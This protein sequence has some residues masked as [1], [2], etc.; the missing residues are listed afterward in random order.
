VDW[1]GRLPSNG[2]DLK[3]L[4]SEPCTTSTRPLTV[5]ALLNLGVIES[6]A[7]GVLSAT[8]ALRLFFHADNCL[9]V[10]NHLRDKLAN[11]IMSHGTQLPDLFTILP[12][13]EAHREFHRELAT[14]R[15]L[16]LKLLDDKRLVA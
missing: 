14:M 4:L 13:D 2:I 7:N 3:D 1:G 12:A 6:L 9:F 8:D 5:Y 10:R 11:K 16:C 15:A